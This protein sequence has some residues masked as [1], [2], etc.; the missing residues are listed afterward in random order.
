M[1]GAYIWRRWRS[2]VHSRA[3]SAV[4]CLAGC[5][6]ERTDRMDFSGSESQEKR[7]LVRFWQETS[8]HQQQGRRPAGKVQ[9]TKAQRAANGLSAMD[10][11]TEGEILLLAGKE[12]Q[13]GMLHVKSELL[14]P[15]L[16]PQTEILQEKKYTKWLSYD[17][18]NCNACFRRRRAGDYLV[19]NDQGGRREAA[20]DLYD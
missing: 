7:P 1:S 17:T 12:Q 20:K 19:I 5:G 4:Y 14:D 6:P 9:H 2:F 10:K 8:E 11:G 13:V 3:G 18:I 16:V 15:S